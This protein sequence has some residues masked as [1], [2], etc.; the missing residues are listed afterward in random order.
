[1]DALEGGGGSPWSL[2]I[3]LLF[4]LAGTWMLVKRER[5]QKWDE[6]LPPLRSMTKQLNQ[7][8]SVRAWKYVMFPCVLIGI[9]SLGV[10][11]GLAALL[12]N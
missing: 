2:L 10:V 6:E 9:G 4:L 5:V 8:G 11:A 7:Y 12:G 3:G 1:V